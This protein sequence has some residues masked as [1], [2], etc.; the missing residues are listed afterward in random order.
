MVRGWGLFSVWS[1][2]E[3]SHVRISPMI[4]SSGTV[5][6]DG[7]HTAPLPPLLVNMLGQHSAMVRRCPGRA[8]TVW[9]NSSW[10]GQVLLSRIRCSGYCAAPPPR[11]AARS[12]GC[13]SDRPWRVPCVPVPSGA[14]PR[15]RYRPKPTTTAGTG[16]PRNGDKTPDRQRGPTSLSEFTCMR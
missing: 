1:G 13:G 2:N 10:C 8:A 14:T 11:S 3:G 4:R 7:G 5:F 12:G 6:A 9:N 16:W 15:S